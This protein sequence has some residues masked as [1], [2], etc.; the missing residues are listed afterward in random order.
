MTTTAAKA[1]ALEI[2]YIKIFKVSG[3]AQKHCL[4]RVLPEGS[5]IESDHVVLLE[6]VKSIIPHAN[7]RPI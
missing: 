2:Q 5:S 1:K 3:S 4:P 6:L 7:A